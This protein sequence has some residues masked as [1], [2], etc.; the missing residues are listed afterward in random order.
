MSRRIADNAEFNKLVKSMR[1]KAFQKLL[2]VWYNVFYDYE[3]SPSA[4]KIMERAR[5]KRPHLNLTLRNLARSLCPEDVV[6]MLK[7]SKRQAWEYV[8]FFRTIYSEIQA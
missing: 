1:T 8:K 2:L 5:Q 3:N 7:I 6:E 4:A